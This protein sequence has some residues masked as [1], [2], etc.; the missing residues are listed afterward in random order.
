MLALV[1]W[2]KTPLEHKIDLTSASLRPLF[3]TG[4]LLTMSSCGNEQKS[5]KKLRAKW[6]LVHV[7]NA[8]GFRKGL[9]SHCHSVSE[10][11]G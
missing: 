6:T 7:P 2:A 3:L 11:S 5:K 9:C 4:V 1:I 8:G 10:E